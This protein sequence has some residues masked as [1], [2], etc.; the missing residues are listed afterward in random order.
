MSQSTF[1]WIV[2]VALLLGVVVV[3]HDI[4]AKR[5]YENAVRI[6]TEAEFQQQ[7]QNPLKPSRSHD[8]IR[9]DYRERH[10]PKTWLF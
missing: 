7:A 10:K 2:T 5:S 3:G 8:E 1:R 4:W 9:R 6:W